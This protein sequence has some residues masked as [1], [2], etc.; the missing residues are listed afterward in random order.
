MPFRRDIHDT[1][2][3]DRALT[4]THSGQR[5]PTRASRPGGHRGGIF[6]P[7]AALRMLSAP[8]L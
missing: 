7:S 8:L 5:F 3:A 6:C 4:P 1:A 2:R